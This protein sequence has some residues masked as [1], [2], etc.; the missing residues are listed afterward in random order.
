ME[1]LKPR[2]A[3]CKRIQPLSDEFGGRRI[4]SA[5][6]AN[7]FCFGTLRYC[8]PTAPDFPG[9]SNFVVSL[10]HVPAECRRFFASFS[11]WQSGSS[12]RCRLP[13]SSPR[14]TSS[15]S[16]S[17]HV[18]RSLLFSLPSGSSF[19]FFLSRAPRPGYTIDRSVVVSRHGSNSY[20]SIMFSCPASN[21][22]SIH[23][24]ST[25]LSFFYDFQVAG[26]VRRSLGFS[27]RHTYFR[28]CAAT[29]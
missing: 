12:S 23:F 19:F 3:I 13:S 9:F 28:K 26:A 18:R 25:K 27:N 29:R 2:S 24:S 21:L 14:S 10:R 22:F 20:L 1:R 16:A 4:H 17:F 5:G 11:G 15:S 7:H 6:N 8:R